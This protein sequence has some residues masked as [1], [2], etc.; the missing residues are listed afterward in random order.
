MGDG[1][2]STWQ[3]IGVD[4]V[5]TST[6]G[7]AKERTQGEYQQLIEQAGFHFKQLYPVEAPTSIIE[8][9]WTKH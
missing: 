8:G 9:I 2:V 7:N 3:A 1:A 4:M 5:M 6:F